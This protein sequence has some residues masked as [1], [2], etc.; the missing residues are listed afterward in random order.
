M[1]RGAR[2]LPGRSSSRLRRDHK[3]KGAH[4][5]NR[6]LPPCYYGKTVFEKVFLTFAPW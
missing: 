4:G 2:A 1:Y 6:P 3:G 5:G